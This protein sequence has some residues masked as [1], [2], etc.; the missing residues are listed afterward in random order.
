M[1]ALHWEAL[2]KQR[3]LDR[4]HFIEKQLKEKREALADQNRREID[5]YNNFKNDDSRRLQAAY[6]KRLNEMIPCARGEHHHS[7]D[8]VRRRDFMEASQREYT[9]KVQ[10]RYSSINYAQ[11]W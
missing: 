6:D 9:A 4:K 8:P 7:Q 5:N 3:V 1:S 11:Q 2:R 10:N